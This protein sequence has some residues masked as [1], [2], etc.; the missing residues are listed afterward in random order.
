MWV[1]VTCRGLDD[2]GEAGV[3]CVFVVCAC[4]GTERAGCA[5]VGGGCVV[6][7]VCVFVFLGM[8]FLRTGSR[9]PPSS[10]ALEL[11]QP[12]AGLSKAPPQPQVPS[13]CCPNCTALEG[14]ATGICL[15][16]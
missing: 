4:L 10:L 5:W 2:V 16:A 7:S 6:Y 15:S 12:W 1:A 14:W 8:E 9:S 3:M 11:A 13:C